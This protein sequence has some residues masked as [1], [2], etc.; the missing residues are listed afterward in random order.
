MSITDQ[1]NY[2]FANYWDF[3]LKGLLATIILSIVGTIGGLFLG[4]FLAFG[5]RIEINKRLPWYAQ[6]W[7]YLIK[8]ICNIYSTVIRGT[9]MMVQAMIFKYGCQAAGLN[10][11]A[12]LPNVDVFNGWLVAGLIV[13]TFNTA[14]YM[15]EVVIS[16]LNGVDKGQTEGARSLGLNSFQTMFLVTLPQALKNSIP[17][18]GNEWIVNIKDSSVLNVIGVSELYF[19]SGQ[20]ANKNYMFIAA[21]VIL[22]CIY[23]I[24]TLLTT[25]ILKILDQKTK[26]EKFRIPFFH[27][28]QTKGSN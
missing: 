3:F 18:I 27:F 11:N 26:G 13:I 5:K 9:P 4:L 1:I 25:G 14:A 10:W 15:G 12:V 28:G 17:T 8:Y 16:G 6:I 19:M 20:A 23:L 7:K 21:Y 24:M 2:L 22:A